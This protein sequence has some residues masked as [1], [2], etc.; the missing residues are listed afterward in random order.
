MKRGQKVR[1]TRGC[2]NPTCR[3]KCREQSA[4]IEKKRKANEILG[5]SIDSS[6]IG[7]KNDIVTMTGQENKGKSTA[8][9]NWA[10]RMGAKPGSIRF[11]IGS[12][13][14]EKEKE[15]LA[16][17]QAD[18]LRIR[19]EAIESRKQAIEGA[20]KSPIVTAEDNNHR[21]QWESFGRLLGMAYAESDTAFFA[22]LEGFYRG[23][24][25]EMEGRRALGGAKP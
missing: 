24:L 18:Y 14:N 6:K 8:T 22:L 10:E 3:G 11:D 4:A 9:I 20:Y 23:R 25:N 13:M 7:R 12:Y 1:H 17:R 21:D 5:F 16:K 2:R 19:D 15:L